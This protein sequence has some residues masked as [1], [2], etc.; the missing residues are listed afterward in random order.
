MSSQIPDTK[1]KI[2]CAISYMTLGIW[3][4]IWLLV[5]KTPSHFQK[6]FIRFHC[7]QSI[8]LGV[9]YMFIPYG[10]SIL[11]HLV[12][13]IIDLIPTLAPISQILHVI[14]GSIQSLITLGGLAL[15]V[16]CVIFCLYGKYTNIP[17]IS[18]V[19]NRMLR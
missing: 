1:E 4:L 10:V 18:Q 15:I 13:Q 16:Y 8:F 3:G 14:H 7:Y 9:L 11:F 12:I 19:I 5:S 2:G 6:D 17:W